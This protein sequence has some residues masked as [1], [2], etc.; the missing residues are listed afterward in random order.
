MSSTSEYPAMMDKA[1]ELG[2]KLQNT[3]TTLSAE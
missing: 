2:E 3:S 1:N